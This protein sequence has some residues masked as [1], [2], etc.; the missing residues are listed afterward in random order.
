MDIWF[1]INPIPSNFHCNCWKRKLRS[2][3]AVWWR[4][5]CLCAVANFGFWYKQLL[6][7]QVGRCF[8][9]LRVVWIWNSQDLWTLS[10]TGQFREVSSRVWTVDSTQKFERTFGT[11]QYVQFGRVW[12]TE[13]TWKSRRA[14][15]WWAHFLIC[16]GG[17]WS[18]AGQLWDKLL[19][20][21]W[22]NRLI[23]RTYTLW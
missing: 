5:H 8:F 6:R 22:I 7:W 9:F 16:E 18:P 19:N 3:L 23:H 21:T 4:N 1:Q 11:S 20:Y 2:T 12:H 13:N 14:C 10:L 17:M 15:W